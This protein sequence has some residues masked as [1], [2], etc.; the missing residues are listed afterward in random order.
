MFRQDVTRQD[1]VLASCGFVPDPFRSG[2]R[3]SIS[4]RAMMRRWRL[5]GALADREQRGVA[6]VALDVELLGVAVGAV[7]AHRFEAVEERGLG[8]EELGH[9]RFEVAALSAL[10]GAGG[11]LG[12]Q[13]G[14]L[15]AGRHLRELDLDGL[16]L[17]DRL[18]ES[19]SHLRVRNG[20][21]QAGAGDAHPARGDVDPAEL[22]PGEDLLEAAALALADEVLAG[23][24]ALVEHQLA[25]SM[26]L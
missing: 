14:R 25:G 12:E 16:V 21:L 4:C 11:L 15:Q 6:V 19:L 10:V 18:A 22:Q 3:R 8:R 1:F 2:G 26:P 7:E 23:H 20:F 24:L 17:A 9:A 13:A 5:V